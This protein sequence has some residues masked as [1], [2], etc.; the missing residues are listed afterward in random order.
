MSEHPMQEIV[1]VDDIIRFRK[2]AIVSYMLGEGTRTG[3]FDLNKIACLGFSEE[4]HMQ[5]AQ[6]I[7]YSV[8]GYGDLSFVSGES[9]AKA[10]A[11]ADELIAKG[12]P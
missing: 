7:G 9:A 6:L 12:V 10:D 11:I 4:D 1:W 3:L 2:N 5:L 8:S